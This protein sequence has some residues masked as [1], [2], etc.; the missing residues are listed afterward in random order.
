MA[1]ECIAPVALERLAP[2]LA[3][4][5]NLHRLAV[6]GEPVSRLARK[7]GDGGV[8]AAAKPAFRGHHHKQ[9]DLVAA[10]AR[11]ETRRPGRTRGRLRQPR[12]DGG[13]AFGIGPRRLGRVLGA[14]QLGGGDHLHRLGDL[15]GRFDRR[16][17]VLEG[18][19]TGHARVSL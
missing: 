9:V 1:D 13:E 3:D 7:L 6:T 5:Q 15:A 12:H 18:L 19:Q 8:E 4:G 11:K 10:R 2:L 14:A 16:D 17:P